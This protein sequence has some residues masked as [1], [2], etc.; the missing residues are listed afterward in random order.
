MSGFPVQICWCSKWWMEES[1]CSSLTVYSQIRFQSLS[2]K[3]LGKHTP[4]LSA[5]PWILAI[6]THLPPSETHSQQ[7]AQMANCPLNCC[8]VYP[9]RNYHFTAAQLMKRF[10]SGKR[11]WMEAIWACACASV[12]P[13]RD[14]FKAWLSFFV[15]KIALHACLANRAF[16]DF[17]FPVNLYAF[18][19]CVCSLELH[20]S[21]WNIVEQI[22]AFMSRSVLVVKPLCSPCKGICWA[23][24]QY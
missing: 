20:V 21:V 6:W 9:Q 18:L 3:L 4:G 14:P 7:Q 11:K 17:G 1:F 22:C 13:C 16:C 24:H 15:C 23:V 5:S 10:R 19:W 12:C 8:K 2:I